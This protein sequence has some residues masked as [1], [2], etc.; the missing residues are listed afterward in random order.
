MTY[1][2][3][4]G[5]V[6]GIFRRNIYLP[7]DNNLINKRRSF[8]Q[9]CRETDVYQCIYSYDTDKR[10]EV[11]TAP[12]LAPFYLDLDADIQTPK[13][14]EYIRDV[15]V[16][17]VYILHTIF[18]IP[19]SKIQTYF[20]GHKGFHILIDHRIFGLCPLQRLNDIYKAWAI[21]LSMEYGITNL[22]VKIYDRRRLFRLPNTINSKTGLYKVWIPLSLL[23]E[24]TYE[25]I[26]EYARTPKFYFASPDVMNKEAAVRFLSKARLIYTKKPRKKDTYQI[27]KQK[28]EL[29]P[30]IKTLLSEGVSEGSRNK[31]TILLANSLL[32]RGY[33]QEEMRDMVT[34]WNEY[35]DP[36][37]PDQELDITIQSAINSLEKGKRYGCSSLKEAGICVSDCPMNN[38]K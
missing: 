8:I 23:K 14:Y 12:I 15:A 29:L 13:D 19:L 3:L 21:H 20:S 31:M 1:T 22:D 26:K 7:E 25:S 27:P 4:G 17:T 11:D 34:E 2:E 33:T 30:C 32:Q 9:S 10:E 6:N 28:E 35:N 16:R 18:S 36:P 5:V 24:S 38:I 37:L